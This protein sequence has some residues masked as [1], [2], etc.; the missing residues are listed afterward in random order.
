[1]GIELRVFA[2]LPEICFYTGVSVWITLCMNNKFLF[3]K[4]QPKRIGQQ[5]VANFGGKF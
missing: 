1:M 4:L 5:S 3:L 2:L